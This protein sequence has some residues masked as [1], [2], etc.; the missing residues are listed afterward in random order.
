M[1]LIIY[2]ILISQLSYAK[3]I[4]TLLLLD[5]SVSNDTYIPSNKESQIEAAFEIANDELK[6]KYP[7][8][9]INFIKQIKRSDQLNIFKQSDKIK[10][11]FN[12]DK[13]IIIGLIHS[14]EALLAAKA[15]TGT[16]FQVL[17][18]GATTENINEI[19]SNFYTLAN[20]VSSFTKIM[21]DFIK[22]RKYRSV[23]SLIP[24]DSSYAK[25]FSISLKNKL[26]GSGVSLNEIE[27]N[28]TD[29]ENNL[30]KYQAQILNSDLIF[31][32]GFIQQSLAAASVISKFDRIKPILGTPNWGRSVPDL[33]NFYSK[34][35][36]KKNKIYF[37][38]SWIAGETETSKKL[39]NIFKN[40]YQTSPMGTA[41]YTYDAAVVA[42]SYLCTHQVVVP[43]AFKQYLMKAIFQNQTAR[44]YEKLIAGHM[45]SNISMIEFVN[46]KD[47]KSAQETVQKSDQKNITAKDLK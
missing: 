14:S 17:S 9:K 34:L 20:P 12:A 36:I 19:N 38:V 30:K 47:L 26:I 4:K 46:G 35:D 27:Y 29:V 13:T 10:K 5:N 40:K 11:V 45:K 3:G 41:I 37:P 39:E 24:G 2:T 25:E 44:N 33:I 18:S 28:P 21:M 16:A 15:F 42:G 32:P 31:A 6:N 7:K 1:V 8:C 23:L 22:S 43:S